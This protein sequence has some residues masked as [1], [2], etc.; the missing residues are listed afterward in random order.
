MITIKRANE[1][2]A[3]VGHDETCK[4]PLANSQT[5]FKELLSHWE[6]H[7]DN[8]DRSKLLRDALIARAKIT[9]EFIRLLEFGDAR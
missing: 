1:M 6:L 3:L 4:L 8:E 7:F 2:L 9:E 5:E